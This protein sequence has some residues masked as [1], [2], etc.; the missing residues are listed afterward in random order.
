LIVSHAG[1]MFYL[2]KELLRRGFYGPKFGIADNGR[3][4]VFERK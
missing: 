1:M 4:Y 3:L 2:R